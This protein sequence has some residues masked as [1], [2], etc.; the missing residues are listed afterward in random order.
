[1]Q[2]ESRFITAEMCVNLVIFFPDNLNNKVSH[3][4]Q[5]FDVDDGILLPFDTA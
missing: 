2:T 1:M 4:R 3:P 5:R